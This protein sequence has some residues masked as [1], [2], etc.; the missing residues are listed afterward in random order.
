MLDHTYF[1]SEIEVILAH[2]DSL[3]NSLFHQRGDTKG[4]PAEWQILQHIKTG[5]LSLQSYFRLMTHFEPKDY[6]Q[7]IEKAHKGLN[8]VR[9]H[10]AI[11]QE[12]YLLFVFKLIII[13][14]TK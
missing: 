9:T 14:R 2:V 7:H 4:T 8:S 10:D 1:L 12:Q 6:V 5:L 11:G 3:I 13:N